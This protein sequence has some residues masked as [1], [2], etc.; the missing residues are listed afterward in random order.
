[1]LVLLVFAGFLLAGGLKVNSVEAINETGK[2]GTAAGKTYSA[3]TTSFGSDT[4]C[5]TGYT[6]VLND[7]GYGGFYYPAVGQNA[8]WQCQ[9]GTEAPVNC[10][11]S[12]SRYECSGTPPNGT[13]QIMC[14]GDDQNLEQARS[15]TSLGVGT[16]AANCSSIKCQYF[17]PAVVSPCG[18]FAKNYTT[19]NAW[20]ADVPNSFCNV[21]GWYNLVGSR[22]DFP[23]S[24]SPIS[25]WQC[26]Y[27]FGS[28]QT[29]TCSATKTVAT[30]FSCGTLPANTEAS[31]SYEETGLTANGNWKYAYPNTTAKCEYKCKAGYIWNNTSC[32]ANATIYSC[33]TLPTNAE[34]SSAYEETGLT[35]NGTWKYAYPNKIDKCEYKCK[36]G[37]NWNNTACVASANPSA[38]ACE[39]N[40]DKSEITSGQSATMTW[41]SV[42][43]ADGR[44]DFTCTSFGPINNGVLTYNQSGRSSFVNS[45]G[46]AEATWVSPVDAI[47]TC[48]FTAKNG[49]NETAVCSDSLAVKKINSAPSVTLAAS[50]STINIGD[51]V[52]MIYTVSGNATSCNLSLSSASENWSNKPM[53]YANGEHESYNIPLRTVGEN[54][55]TLTCKNTGGTVSKIVKVIVNSAPAEGLPVAVISSPQNRAS[56]VAGKEVSFTGS[57]AGAGG[58]YRWYNG[59]DTGCGSVL[60]ATSSSPTGLVRIF[61]ENGNNN[62]NATALQVETAD[63]KKS[64]NNAVVQLNIT[65]NP[66]C[67]NNIKDAGEYGVDCGGS[68]CQVCEATLPAPADLSA[69]CSGGLVSVSWSGVTGADRY[70]LIIKKTNSGITAPQDL[71]KDD[72]TGTSYE[73]QGVADESYYYSIRAIKEN[74]TRDIIG[75]AKS[76]MPVVSCGGGGI[77]E[78]VLNCTATSGTVSSGESFATTLKVYKTKKVEFSCTNFGEIEANGYCLSGICTYDGKNSTVKSFENPKSDMRFNLKYINN[79]DSAKSRVCTYNVYD[80]KGNKKTCTNTVIVNTEEDILPPAINLC[81]PAGSNDQTRPKAYSDVSSSYSGAFCV[82][83]NPNP[84]IPDF[85]EMGQTEEWV[86]SSASGTETQKCYAKRNSNVEPPVCG[87][88]CPALS[89]LPP[90][91][92]K[93]GKIVSG[94]KDNCGCE[95]PPICDDDVVAI[96]QNYPTASFC[97]GGTKDIIITGKDEKDCPIYGCKGEGTGINVACGTANKF[98]ESTNASF[99]NDTFCSNG[100]ASPTKP[101]FP[102][103][104]KMVEWKC[105]ESGNWM[106]DKI[107]LKKV[108]SCAAGRKSESINPG[109]G[110]AAGNYSEN[111][112][113]FR[114]ENFCMDGYNLS[115]AKPAFPATVG[116]SVDWVCRP[117]LLNKIFTNKKPVVCNATKGYGEPTTTGTTGDGLLGKYFDNLDFTAQKV[118]KKDATIDF[119]WNQDRP[120]N[121]IDKD[122]FSIRWEGKVQPKHT[123]EWTFHVTADDGVRFWVNGQLLV[124]KWIDQDSTEYTGKINLNANQKYDIKMEYYE[125]G[126]DAVARLAWSHEKQGE[127][128][129]PQTHLYSN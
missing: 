12:R 53:L 107:L 46:S 61:Q 119:N 74:G 82:H 54:T 73:W 91:W 118:V 79:S 95:K 19:E 3:E 104:G 59:L 11:A 66:T 62:W 96:C 65:N 110:D 35:S 126:G 6:Q 129:I 98:Y 123:G 122:T 125:N 58:K 42:N 2:C 24:I 111:E 1:M 36:T 109:C 5:A 22:P 76:P 34:P 128:V 33:G 27:S 21:S 89:P 71:K 93:D 68:V 48:T 38:P 50:K 117:N 43:D 10:S 99:G 84:A 88:T 37:F 40:Y 67:H 101:E 112:N 124:D 92:C 20:P 77:D 17:E 90:D 52:S 9:K 26:K 83:G 80:D 4:A 49:N 45:S 25:T 81:G 97:A 115:S 60:L 87:E 63:G 8:N 100:I 86:C 94:G 103:Q 28:Q 39:V 47:E 102:E 85:P 29:E 127:E 18:S 15:W 30:A 14:P 23:T 75:E 69:T 44:L 70:E 16:T 108:V 31:S 57:G 114:S 113:N 72:I 121:D 55:F 64:T 7:V 32:V 51:S 105:S 78:S 56:F 41:T 116:A 106:M 120:N 13:T